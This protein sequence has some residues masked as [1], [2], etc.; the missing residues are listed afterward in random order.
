M[1]KKRERRS[2]QVALFTRNNT[3]DSRFDSGLAKKISNR[4]D[5]ARISITDRNG[6]PISISSASRD[7][8]RLRSKSSIVMGSDLL[9]SNFDQF[10]K[11]LESARINKDELPGK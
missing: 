4:T 10:K 6:I 3:I 7:K 11:F 8:S 1:D 9:N 2:T 5:G